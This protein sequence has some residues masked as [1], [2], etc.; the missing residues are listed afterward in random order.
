MR[1]ERLTASCYPTPEA[2]GHRSRI[3]SSVRCKLS[4][5]LL[6]SHVQRLI[7][8]HHRVLQ[9]WPILRL[10]EVGVEQQYETLIY[11]ICRFDR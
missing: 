10:G 7:L 2:E 5:H 4:R 8:A 3:C 9:W 1:E 11:D 6:V